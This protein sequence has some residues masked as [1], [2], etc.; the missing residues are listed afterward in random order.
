MD[1]FTPTDRKTAQE[2]EE[3]G[4][5]LLSEDPHI[6]RLQL[7]A[8][9]E[10][11]AAT[12]QESREFAARQEC[13]IHALETLLAQQQDHHQAFCRTVARTANQITALCENGDL[14]YVRLVVGML[15]LL[16]I[17]QQ[18]ALSPQEEAFEEAISEAVPFSEEAYDLRILNREMRQLKD[19]APPA[20]DIG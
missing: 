8:L 11:L 14:G 7:A 6:L 12:Q 15:R 3:G 10:Q 16:A 9:T 13:L 20:D 5:L 2:G 4:I 19:L 18:Q 17:S 1:A